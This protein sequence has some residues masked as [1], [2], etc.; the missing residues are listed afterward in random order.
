[1][2]IR[3]VYALFKAIDVNDDLRKNLYKCRNRRELTN[4]LELNHLSF[5]FDEFEEAINVMH[6]SCQTK[7]AASELFGKSNWYKFLYYSISSK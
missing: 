6:A 5:S 1:M 7:E 4:C 3:N 2:A